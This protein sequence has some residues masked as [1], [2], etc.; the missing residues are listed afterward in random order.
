MNNR[1]C[2]LMHRYLNPM[3]E[4]HNI[5]SLNIANSV[6]RMLGDN[7]AM[8]TLEDNALTH[9]ADDHRVYPIKLPSIG[10]STTA[11]VW[12]WLPEALTTVRVA[13]VIESLK[14]KVVHLLNVTKE[15]YVPILRILGRRVIV[16]HLYHS[17]HVFEDRNFYQ[18]H[19]FKLRSLALKY[20]FFD[21]IF[22]TT[23][24]LKEYLIE[25]FSLD[26]DHVHYVPYPIDVN[27]FSPITE[28]Y[29]VE[30]R[31][32]YK[33]PEDKYI[34]GFVGSVLEP[35][36]GFHILISALRYIS[37]HTRGFLLIVAST[38][39]FTGKIRR[40]SDRTSPLEMIN[41]YHLDPYV[42]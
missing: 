1:V 36:R 3:P 37:Q 12:K 28:G 26:E 32:K 30:L 34:V 8:V 2:F 29:K 35:L 40:S 22:C 41:A 25:K 9:H 38:D 21:H 7:V 18:R 13:K 6:F 31:R 24:S 42:I 10:S 4:G 39:P 16:S 20:K 27:F 19:L 17:S 5:A 15:A 14:P 33:L 11:N 23:N